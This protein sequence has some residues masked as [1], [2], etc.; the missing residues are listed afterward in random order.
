MPEDKWGRF[1][2]LLD[3]NTGNYCPKCGWHFATHDDDGS[4]IEVFDDYEKSEGHLCFVGKYEFYR[5]GADV[6]KA[7]IDNLVIGKW[8]AASWFCTI[9]CWDSGVLAIGD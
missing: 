6:Y 5:F 4:C 1:K 9:A 2:R 3:G 7:H 8:R